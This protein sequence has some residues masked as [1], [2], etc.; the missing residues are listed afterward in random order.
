MKHLK[1][2]ENKYWIKKKFYKREL[3]QNGPLACFSFLRRE[4]LSSAS[5]ALNVLYAKHVIELPYAK[6][7]VDAQIHMH[8]LNCNV[9][10]SG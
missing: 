4:S 8:S 5:S 2:S 1:D 6:C 9:F 3:N 10:N 7:A